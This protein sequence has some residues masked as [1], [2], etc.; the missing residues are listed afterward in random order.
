MSMSQGSRKGTVFL[1][2]AS[3]SIFP[4]A[5]QR[6]LSGSAETKL[7]LERLNVTA[8]VL[9]I[10]AHPDDENTALLAYFSRGR[11]ARTGYL[12]LTR[13]E[14]GQ[15]LI[16]SEQGDA[17]GV[18]RTQELLAAR[19]IDG[20]EQFFTRAI[21]F[22]F[23]KTTQETFEK[24]GHE[25]ILSDVVWVIRRFRPEVI[26]L[27]F[28]GTP[29]DGHGQHQAS[30]ILG[31]EAFTAAADRTRFPEQLEWVQPWQAKRLMWN[32]FSFNREQERDAE[33]LT[34]RVEAD[35]GDFDPV[36]GHSYGEIA[37]MSRSLHRS[38]GM[39]APE[40]K[41]SQK[42]YLVTIAGDPATNDVFDGID[43]TWD[44]VP[45]SGPLS[46]LLA[47]A[48]R[49]F[50]PEHPEK[51]VPLLLK[52]EPLMAA[53]HHPIAERKHRELLDAIAL[54]SG[55]WLEA[56]AD[57]YAVMPGGTLKFNAT[58]LNRESVPF[59]LEAVD[60]EGIAQ[61]P[62]S[63]SGAGPLPRNIARTASLVA[64]VPA[65]QPYSQPYWLREP[66][67]GATYT[68]SNQLE[69]GMAEAPPLFQSHFRVRAAGNEL[70]F[71]RP[72]VFRYVDRVQ[73]E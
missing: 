32:V 73:G 48:S 6:E 69:I 71:V 46:Q 5:A 59:E 8:S 39:G 49:T 47:E 26:V 3:L 57:R 38:Q 33:K 7:A 53:L 20:A 21:D 16:G 37:G 64:T 60:I 42:N 13:G 72:V 14:G 9:M 44:S 67:Q 4:L 58:A 15:N 1:V 43:K 70:E 17:L 19:R 50:E 25:K 30:A 10:A 27:R 18:I 52:A 41:G 54:A 22:G 66:K 36:L 12:S 23:T 68:V 51:T 56:T 40:R 2:L 31:K 55:L 62:A 24:W 65:D 35:P 11:K 63:H 34:G 61:C 28:S 29:R 45:G